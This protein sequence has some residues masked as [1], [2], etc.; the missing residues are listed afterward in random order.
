MLSTVYESPAALGIRICDVMDKECLEGCGVR[1][2]E[3]SGATILSD[4]KR[5]DERPHFVHSLIRRCNSTGKRSGLGQTCTELQV[6]FFVLKKSSSAVASNP[7]HTL[8]KTNHRVP[9]E[10]D[11]LM[12]LME[13]ENAVADKIQEDPSKGPCTMLFLEE[14]I[15]ETLYQLLSLDRSANLVRCVLKVAAAPH[16][17]SWLLSS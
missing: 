12:V 14:N 6:H 2:R 8:I 13:G 10:L 5:A 9:E 7:D 17:S 4:N 1:G 15:M 11:G 3:G 16:S